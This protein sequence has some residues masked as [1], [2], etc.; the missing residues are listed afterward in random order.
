MQPELLRHPHQ[1]HN[2]RRY[3]PPSLT[4][5]ISLFPPSAPSLYPCFSPVLSK[6]MFGALKLSAILLLVASLAAAV[7]QVPETT[8]SGGPVTITWTQ[9]PTLPVF[10][11]ELFH[12]DFNNAIAI[13]NNVNPATGSL[14]VNLPVVPSDSGYTLQFV[15]ITDINQVYDT[16]P[17]FSIAPP[18]STTESSSASATAS[19]TA[20][21]RSAGSVTVT[22]PMS[23]S[24]ASP[25]KSA[26][27][28]ASASVSAQST[29]ASGAATR[30]LVHS[31]STAGA[32]GGVVLIGLLSAA[33]VL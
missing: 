2:G 10:S 6:K 1:V 29:T 16:S 17:E 20:E 28:S 25:A 14:V 8:S 22:M 23:G 9:D 7:I 21:S 30:L 19:G 31:A 15:N 24:M 3:P 11:M 27:A 18:V 32:L 13:A 26:S 4:T 12:K 5:T 33:W